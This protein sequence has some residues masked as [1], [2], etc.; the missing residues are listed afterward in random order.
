MEKIHKKEKEVFF[1]PTAYFSKK[2]M[3]KV[4][5]HHRRKEKIAR[6]LMLIFAVSNIVVLLKSVFAAN[7]QEVL[8]YL[9]NS[10]SDYHISIAG[11]RFFLSNV[12]TSNV[13]ALSL[14]VNFTVLLVFLAYIFREDVWQRSKSA[15]LNLK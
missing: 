3:M 13:V 12:L 5:E 14:A 6:R 2:V 15:I 1:A 8:T 11:V 4:W 9:S 7:G 10:L